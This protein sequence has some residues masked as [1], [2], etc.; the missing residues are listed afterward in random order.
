MESAQG[1]AEW[2][3]A[4]PPVGIYAVLFAVSYLENLVPPI[5]GDTLIVLCGWLV[6]IGTISFVPTVGVATLGG[7]LGFMTLYAFGRRMDEAIADPSRLR[8]IPRAPL[9]AAERWLK[10][11]GMGVVILNRFLA[12]GRSVISLLAGASKLPVWKTAI[13]SSV[14]A[15][16][17]CALLVSAGAWVGNQW[18][19]VLDALQTYGQVITAL[20]AVI[21]LFGGVRWW[22]R[23]RRRPGAAQ[24]TAKTPPEASGEGSGR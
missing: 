14:S 6:G 21:V 5:W 10:R 20:V 19:M 11:W 9:A 4:L 2:L 12:G 15:L 18:D 22:Q 16:L 3:A 7:S 23:R 17:W 24:E 1:L 13:W 8:W